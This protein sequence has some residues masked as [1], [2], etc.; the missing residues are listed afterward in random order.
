MNSKLPFHYET[1]FEKYEELFSPEEKAK[2]FDQIAK[3]YYDANFGTM[4]KADLEVLMFSLYLERILD[5]S[6]EDMASY[7]DYALSKLLGISQNR[8]RRLKEKKELKYPYRN[9]DWKKSFRRICEHVRYEN[10]KIVLFVPD[11][12]LLNEIKN[13]IEEKNGIIE[14][15]FNSKLLVVAPEYFIDLVYAV[16]E[17]KE[18]REI[19]KN[20]KN[21][22]SDQNIDAD[23]LERQSLGDMFKKNAL[24]GGIEVICDLI[25]SC[26]PGIGAIVAQSILSGIKTIIN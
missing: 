19:R 23:F 16:S 25:S 26:V 2:A 20:L 12:N 13:A 18:R 22:L 8:I 21:K 6:E 1:C 24:S 5:Q 14:A 4:Q 9:F 3:Q 17:D 7:S 11:I 15:S 10:K